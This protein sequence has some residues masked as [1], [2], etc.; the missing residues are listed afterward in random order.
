MDSSRPRQAGWGHDAETALAAA[1][2]LVGRRN[3]A[4]R[5]PARDWWREVTDAAVAADE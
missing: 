5:P 3:S 4:V 2:T 1:D